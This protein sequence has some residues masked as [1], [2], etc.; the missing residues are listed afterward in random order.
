MTA[1]MSNLQNSN[2]QT[3]QEICFSH[4]VYIYSWITD[5]KKASGELLS[6]VL[7]SALRA[8]F[9]FKDEK[10]TGLLIERALQST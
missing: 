8:E 4:R 5:W 3:A 10:V 9:T 2:P 6:A 1:E 7:L